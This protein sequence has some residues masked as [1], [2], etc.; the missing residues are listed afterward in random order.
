MGA[1]TLSVDDSFG[2]S[3]TSE[4][5]KF[6]EKVEVLGEDGATWAGCHRVL[7]IV[8]GS[9]AARR[10]VCFLHGLL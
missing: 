5:G 6:V 2:D 7:V 4:V 1:G 9:T 10:D 8:D 3:L